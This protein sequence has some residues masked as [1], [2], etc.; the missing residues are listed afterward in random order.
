MKRPAHFAITVGL[1]LGLALSACGCL[2]SRGDGTSDQEEGSTPEET[3]L[4]VVG[5]MAPDFT[6]AGLDGTSFHLAEHRG[7]V[8]LINW[9]ATWCPP[10]QQEMP[11]LQS[12]VW[13]RFAGPDF[14]MVS[15]ARQE[16]A[17]IVA[18]FVE[19]FQVTWPFLV[20]PDREAFARYAEAFIPRN[21]V[22]G[23]DGRILFQSQGF[24]ETE[25]LEMIET[26]AAALKKD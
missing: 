3:T 13:E 19:K 1:L 6:L 22:I 7:K 12:R 24:E 10:C 15:I 11:H 26:I 18:P 5:Q 17:D 25:F 4:T 8:V 9:F 2:W 14:V 16:E 21:H 20:D 23:R